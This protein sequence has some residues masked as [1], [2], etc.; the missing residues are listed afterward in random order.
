MFLD[1]LL[2]ACGIKVTCRSPEPHREHRARRGLDALRR[3]G[4]G[5]ALRH[6]DPGEV[7]GG[8]GADEGAG[9]TGVPDVFQ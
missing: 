8:G 1:R 7:E 6:D 3:K 9:V 2:M 5:A 4:V